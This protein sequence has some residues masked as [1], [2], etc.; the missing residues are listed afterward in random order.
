[1]VVEHYKTNGQTKDPD[2]K[3]IMRTV[4]ASKPP[5]TDDLP[6]HVEYC[7]KWGGGKSQQ[8]ALDAAAFV[9]ALPSHIVP[10]AIFEK[11]NS[12]N[13]PPNM[14]CPRV[15]SAVV[16]RCALV[17]DEERAMAIT[18]KDISKITAP[19][20]AASF[21]EA[22]RYMQKAVELQAS[23]PQHMQASLSKSRGMMEC[24]MLDYLFEKL[25][26]K[27]Q[28]Q[29]SLS[30]IVDRF[31]GAF[32]E[33][34]VPSLE[35]AP[36][37]P[38]D[39]KTLFDASNNVEAQTMANLG[40]NVGGLLKQKV[41]NKQY[42]IGYMNED[43]SVGLYKIM[44]DG[45]VAQGKDALVIATMADME[46]YV[47]ISDKQ[48]YAVLAEYPTSR[49]SSLDSS[50]FQSIA[51]VAVQTAYYENMP[52]ATDLYIQTA[53]TKGVFVKA[54]SL[55]VGSLTLVPWTS[56]VTKTADEKFKGPTVTVKVSETE[57]YKFEITRSGK[58]AEFI[59][60]WKMHAPTSDEKLTTMEMSTIVVHVPVPKVA[61]FTRK[62][63]MVQCEVSCAVL[64]RDVVHGES[65]VLFEE[66]VVK[67]REFTAVDAKVS[68]KSKAA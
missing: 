42:E 56:A 63:A 62:G 18:A 16:K 28:A 14:L 19:A 22:E 49:P 3:H 20:T 50:F 15:V 68:K 67:K 35:R 65:L 25:D 66:K 13:M 39:G 59:E 38:A 36:D 5:R 46:K 23:H 55:N 61:Q 58:P 7:R 31:I 43:G 60:F 44:Y 34:A 24:D 52:K 12:L 45:S 30:L 41:G 29:T 21:L 6:A 27:T 57:V 2:W 33:G 48:K 47:T 10:R 26:K 37:T 40:F 17:K 9:K 51:T 32:W 1:M 53:P 54:D 4:L 8:F 64:H 11:L